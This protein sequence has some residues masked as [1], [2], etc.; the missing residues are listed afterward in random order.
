[1]IKLNIRG[2]SGSRH[3]HFLF[4][5]KAITGSGEEHVLFNPKTMPLVKDFLG[6]L[7]RTKADA[8]HEADQLEW[9]SR[10]ISPWDEKMTRDD[11][12]DDCTSKDE[13]AIEEA[14][15]LYH[16]SEEEE[17]EAYEFVKEILLKQFLEGNLVFK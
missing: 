17:E 2:S 10:G 13:D 14:I 7:F 6:D 3:E 5:Y 11:Y 9:R 4:N 1:M 16:A 15:D 8:E 12:I